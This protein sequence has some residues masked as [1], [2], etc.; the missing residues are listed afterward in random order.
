[1]VGSGAARANSERL[2]D[3]FS[4]GEASPLAPLPVDYA[5]VAVWQRERMTGDHLDAQLE[6]W[7]EQL[8]DLPPSLEIP[9]DHPRPAERSGRGSA[10]VVEV[11]PELTGALRSLAR[12]ARAT[13]FMTLLAAFQALLA[14]YSGQDDIA[15]GTAIANRSRVETEGIVGFFANTLVLRTDVSGDPSFIELITRAREVSLGAYRHQDLPFERLVKELRPERTLR[16]T[17]LFQ[18]MFVFQNTPAEEL[19]LGGI[20]TEALPLDHGS[21]MFDL[22]LTLSESEDRLVGTLEFASDLFE[23]ATARRIVTDFQRLLARGAETPDRPIRELD[24]LDDSERHRLLVEWNDTATEFPD[25]CIHEIF[26]QRAAERP[27]AIAVSDNGTLLTYQELD[28]RADAIAGRLR[29]LGIGPEAH[30]GICLPRSADAIA[31]MLG[32]LKA[33]GAYVPLD[34]EYPRARLDF[35]IDDARLEVILTDTTRV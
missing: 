18:H 12:T 29:R 7:R 26:E 8:H 14:R 22:T 24:L 35:M 4:H 17:P 31:A 5:D 33:N 34:P 9:T 3:A 28:E 32:T 10:V 13:M 19:V 6:Y 21:A 16:H 30:V 11:G 2:Y 23:P 1:M 20:R 27:D 15:I 25:Q